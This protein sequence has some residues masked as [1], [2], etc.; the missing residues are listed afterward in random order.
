MILKIE[1]LS[2]MAGRKI[3]LCKSL[4]MVSPMTSKGSWIRRDASLC[5]QAMPY[6]VSQAIALPSSL[7]PGSEAPLCVSPFAHSSSALEGFR[8][9]SRCSPP[10]FL[11]S[12]PLLTAVTHI[13]LSICFWQVPVAAALEEGQCLGISCS[14]RF[15]SSLSPSLSG[16]ITLC[17]VC[18]AIH[19]SCYGFLL[20]LIQCRMFYAVKLPELSVASTDPQVLN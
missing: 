2:L 19:W 13:S 17:R 11:L 8:Y 10:W 9:K 16:Q 14:A 7:L 4:S 15:L 1:D 5:P 20:L 3:C 12:P 18:Y 6:H